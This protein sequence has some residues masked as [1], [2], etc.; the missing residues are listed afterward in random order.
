MSV[1]SN[2]MMSLKTDMRFHT[3]QHVAFEGL[4]MI[5]AWGRQNGH[6]FSFTRFF[7]KDDRLP[8]LDSFDALI[9]M[10]GPMGVYEHQRYPWLEEEKRFVK[11]VIDAGMPVLGICLGAQLIASALNATVAPHKH[12]EIGWYPIRFHKNILGHPI[13]LD[14]P[15]SFTVLHWHGD[16]FDIPD[17]A[18]ALASSDGCDNQAFLFKNHVLGLQFHLEIDTQAA[19]KMVQACA[20]EL[21]VAPSVQSADDIIQRS[22]SQNTKKLLNNLLNNWI[23]IN[24]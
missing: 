5:D 22:Y 24:S 13:A 9:V 6:T 16:R 14:M 10:G 21:I 4:G 1:F 12:K 8:S 18:I 20:S 7:E 19:K 3:L 23:S 17:G 2:Q 11:Y 15:E